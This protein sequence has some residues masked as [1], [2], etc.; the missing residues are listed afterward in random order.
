[1]C[2]VLIIL[3]SKSVSPRNSE[4]FGAMCDDFSMSM[5]VINIVRQIPESE[6]PGH[7]SFQIF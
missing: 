7:F 3:I 4:T 1:M 5:V 2:P 6:I